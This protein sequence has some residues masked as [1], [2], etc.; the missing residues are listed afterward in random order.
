MLRFGEHF[1]GKPHYRENPWYDKLFT[2]DPFLAV[3]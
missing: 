1:D 3:T 2:S